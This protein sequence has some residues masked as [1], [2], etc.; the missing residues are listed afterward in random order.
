MSYDKKF[1]KSLISIFENKNY[2]MEKEKKRGK[3]ED[4]NIQLDAFLLN[5]SHVRKYV[6]SDQGRFSE[7]F[8]IQYLNTSV[9]RKIQY[10]IW[11]FSGNGPVNQTKQIE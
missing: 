6:R 5:V 1:L 9:K 7:H 11:P 10:V 2:G 4:L 8:G 3:R